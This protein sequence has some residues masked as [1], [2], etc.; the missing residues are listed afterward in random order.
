MNDLFRPLYTSLT[1][2]GRL[3]TSPYIPGKYAVGEV[4]EVPAEE[5]IKF[6]KG[7]SNIGP[8][9]GHGR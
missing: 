3:L 2:K 4:Q 8:I 1:C 5:G 6:K 7:P 9:R